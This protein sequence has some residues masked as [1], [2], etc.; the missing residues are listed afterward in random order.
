MRGTTEVVEKV[1]RADRVLLSP[2]VIGELL[3]G[4][5]GGSRAAENAGQLDA[6]IETPFVEV[7]TVTRATADRFA[8]I[9]WRLKRK[10]RPIPIN[11]AWIAAQAFE[12]G[13]DLL[14]SD[15]HFGEVEGLAWIGF[16]E[17]GIR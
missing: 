9:V 10:C 11:D 17:A 8:G 13:A 15:R 4:F 16:G 14:S 12:T 7:L 1:R 6:F 2:I 5:R 3:Y